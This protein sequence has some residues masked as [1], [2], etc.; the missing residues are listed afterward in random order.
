MSTNVVTLSSDESLR[1]AYQLMR[2]CGIRHLPIVD[3]DE[4]VG[5]LS[6]GDLLLAAV[7]VPG[8]GVA[9]P[10]LR[11]IADVMSRN[12]ITCFPTSEVAD[13]AAT[14][15]AFKIDALPVVAPDGHV[16]GIVTTTD[17]L[18]V[19]CRDGDAHG[20]HVRPLDRVSWSDEPRAT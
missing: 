17:L 5:M 16:V 9:L 19:L 13:M 2:R 4:L 15:G 11:T 8:H 12:V 1:E 14:M 10:D 6:W 20:P 3:D 7:D 18:D